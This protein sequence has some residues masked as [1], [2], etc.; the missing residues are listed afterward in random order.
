MDFYRPLFIPT[1]LMFCIIF[2]LFFLRFLSPAFISSHGIYIH[3]IHTLLLH[4]LLLKMRSSDLSPSFRWLSFMHTYVGI[5]VHLT[6]ISSPPSGSR[7]ELLHGCTLALLP[8]LSLS[9]TPRSNAV[10]FICR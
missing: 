8:S 1:Y 10:P 7:F 9:S 6:R 4:L 5:H 2:N 3:I